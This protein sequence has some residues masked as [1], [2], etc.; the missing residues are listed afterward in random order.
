MNRRTFPGRP[1]A[2]LSPAAAWP[3]RRLPLLGR[4]G[5]RWLPLRLWLMLIGWG[6]IGLAYGSA[7][8]LQGPGRTL[9]ELLPDRLLPFH[10]LAVWPYLSMFILVPLAYLRCPPQRQYALAA[11]MQCCALLAW[12]CFMLFP[13]TLASYPAADPGTLSGWLL[14]GLMQLD[15]PQNCLPSLHAALTL[16]SVY[17][18]RRCGAGPRAHL[19]NLLLWVWAALIALSIIVLRRHLFIDLLSGLLL[20]QLAAHYCGLAGKRAS[21]STSIPAPAAHG[22][23]APTSRETLS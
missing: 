12:V 10:P 20:G 23:A 1:L 7:H 19:S 17:A 4:R 5:P 2:P 21:T 13:T 6:A 9:P 14:S 16:L 18:L 15:S 11:A 22:A 3:D 8:W